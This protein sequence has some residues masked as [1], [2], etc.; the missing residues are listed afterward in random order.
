[1]SCSGKRNP[2]QIAGMTLNTAVEQGDIDARK[3]VRKGTNGKYVRALRR[4]VREARQDLPDLAHLCLH[5]GG[6][7]RRQGLPGLRQA[8][9]DRVRR[10][11][12]ELL[13]LDDVSD[14]PPP[15]KGTVFDKGW[16]GCPRRVS[17][18]DHL[19]GCDT[20]AVA[21]TI[22]YTQIEAIPGWFRRMDMELFRLL[23]DETEENLGGGDLAELGVYL[24]K[25]ATLM[26]D[27]QPGETFT[28]IDLFGDDAGDERNLEENT[29]QYP[30]LTRGRSRP[31]TGGCTAIC[32]VVVQG[33]ARRSSIT[34]RT[35]PIG[36]CTSTPRTST[37]TW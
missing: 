30:E 20:P 17:V 8:V 25:S 26:G 33:T 21:T 10:L 14:P 29:D 23:L 31:T 24:G 16:P 12:R 13:A 36:S 6:R 11:R 3:A 32:P 37:S 34:Q 15:I 7:R 2:E 27:L 18:V 1:M 35:A 19:S 5:E 4:G 9:A 22:P 28:V